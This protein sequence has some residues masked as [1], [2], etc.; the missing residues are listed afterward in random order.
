[1]KVYVTYGDDN[2]IIQKKNALKFAKENGNFDKIFSF[3]KKDIDKEFYERNSN[4]LNRKRGDGYWIWK[5]YF[6]K[7][8]LSEIEEGDFVFYSDAGAVFLKSVDILINELEKNKQDIMGY[9]LPFIEKQWTKRELFKTMNLDKK[10]YGESNQ[11]LAGLILI[12]KTKFSLNFIDEWLKY[13]CVEQ[14]VTDILSEEQEKCFKEHRHDQSIFS[15][16]Y[17]KYNLKPFKEPT[18]YG[19]NSEFYKEKKIVIKPK[20]YNASCYNPKIYKENYGVVIYRYSGKKLGYSL[21]K[22]KLKRVLLKARLL[23]NKINY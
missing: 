16:L 5:P 8:V 22:Y 19:V 12:K 4:I 10:V 3:S 14:N 7:R 21:I 13:I 17:K 6:I 1:M 18:Q 15:L 23:K 9:E 2:F 11:I 20:H